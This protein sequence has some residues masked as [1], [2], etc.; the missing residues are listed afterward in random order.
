MI[1]RPLTIPQLDALTANAK[2]RREKLKRLQ[3]DQI[4]EGVNRLNE[5]LIQYW[6]QA[7]ETFTQVDKSFNYPPPV[8]QEIRQRFLD[9][10]IGIR[11]NPTKLANGAKVL[12][13]RIVPE[14]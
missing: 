12:E 7:A 4:R 9:N 8:F 13:F 11:Y 6:D 3:Q 10:R 2:L 1:T 14:E 5:I